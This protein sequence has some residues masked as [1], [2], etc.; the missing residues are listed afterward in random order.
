M[1]FSGSIQETY[2]IFP[3][4]SRPTCDP[5]FYLNKTVCKIDRTPLAYV[6]TPVQYI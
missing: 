3:N 1:V 5:D 4:P 6:Q 2:T